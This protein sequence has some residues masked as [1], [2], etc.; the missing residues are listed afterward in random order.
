MPRAPYDAHPPAART[1]AL[2]TNAAASPPRSATTGAGRTT[3]GP[4]DL[5]RRRA[6]DPIEAPG[7]DRPMREGQHA[8]ACPSRPSAPP[9]QPRAHSPRP[10]SRPP[11]RPHR[12]GKAATPGRPATKAGRA[13]PRSMEARSGE[14][15]E[16]T[17]RP[18]W[19]RA[20]G[21]NLAPTGPAGRDRR[22]REDV[23]ARAGR[24]RVDHRRRAS[25]RR[26]MMSAFGPP[27]APR[28][29]PRRWCRWPGSG[30]ARSRAIHSAVADGRL[31]GR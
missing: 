18:C 12:H 16:Q 14:A 8:R 20:S 2:G 15:T 13:D 31:R 26:L 10:P 6:N 23:P 11:A 25:L 7:L 29:R 5:A 30:D 1:A 4:L 9:H 24:A 19:M 27:P 28:S 17:E 22:T 3:T 21:I